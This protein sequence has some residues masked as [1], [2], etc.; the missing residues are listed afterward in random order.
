MEKKHKQ[1][2]FNHILTWFTFANLFNLFLVIPL[3]GI[4]YFISDHI[5]NLGIDTIYKVLLV[6]CFCSPALY[7]LINF[8]FY[9]KDEKHAHQNNEQI[10]VKKVNQFSLFI[11]LFIFYATFFIGLLIFREKPPEGEIPF[12]KDGTIGMRSWQSKTVVKNIKIQYNDVLGIWHLVPDSVI[13]N[14]KNWTTVFW[15]HKKI[16]TQID[17][18]EQRGFP[19]NLFYPTINTINDTVVDSVGHSFF[20]IQNCSLVFTPHGNMQKTFHDMRFDC[21]ITFDKINEPVNYLFPSFKLLSFIDTNKVINSSGKKEFSEICLE[22]SLGMNNLHI[23]FIPGLD[24][25]PPT[26]FVA[27][28]NKQERFG[29]FNNMKKGKEYKISGIVLENKILFLGNTGGSVKLFEAQL[30]KKN[31]NYSE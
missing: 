10:N 14:K 31:K 1:F 22:F 19:E 9:K 20:V 21:T 12:L 25:E 5:L 28:P 4:I 26:K 24:Y 23:P 30:A 18:A 3:F 7:F 13:Y 15:N 17:L 16:K 8:S 29:E 27:T 6:I 11:S 2:K